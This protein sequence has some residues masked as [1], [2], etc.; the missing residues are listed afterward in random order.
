MLRKI[1]W[2]RGSIGSCRT[3]ESSETGEWERLMAHDR[4]NSAKHHQTTC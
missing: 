4:L 2:G 1:R 3:E